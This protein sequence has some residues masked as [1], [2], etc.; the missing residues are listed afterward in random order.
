MVK[1]TAIWT[2]ETE[3]Q[4]KECESEGEWMN[5]RKEKEVK[6]ICGG[7]RDEL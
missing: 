7:S 5:S 4:L 6:H 2:R 3:R 1:S